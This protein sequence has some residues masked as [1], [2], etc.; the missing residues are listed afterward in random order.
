MHGD[1]V[2][3]ERLG[4]R[5]MLVARL[6]GVDRLEHLDRVRVVGR[7]RQ[8]VARPVQQDGAQARPFVVD[9]AIG[10]QIADLFAMR[11]DPLRPAAAA[12][13]R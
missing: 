8:L 2:G 4:H 5:V 1:A 13:R 3:A 7:R 10:P 12:I 6:G 9:A 11:P